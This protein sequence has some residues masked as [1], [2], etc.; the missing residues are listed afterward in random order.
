MK[1]EIIHTDQAPAAIGPYSQAVRI[2]HF[3]YTAGQV[4]IDPA[5]GKLVA[6]EI[7]LQTERALRNLQAILEAAGGSLRDVVK[8]TVFLQDISEFQAMNVVYKEFFMTDPTA[9]SAIEVAG[10]PLGARVEIEAVAW[11]PNPVE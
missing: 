1:R 5:E 4:A 10:L 8:T 6:D 3:L 7:G 11:L 9:R 2:G